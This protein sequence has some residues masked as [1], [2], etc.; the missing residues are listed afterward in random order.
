MHQSSGL[1]CSVA[2]G[3]ESRRRLGANLLWGLYGL[4]L[5]MG[6]FTV[7]DPFENPD[8]DKSYGFF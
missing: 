1:L 5:R 6:Y 7:F 4:R 2:F 3:F 8:S